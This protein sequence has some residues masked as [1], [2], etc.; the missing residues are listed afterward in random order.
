MLIN[1]NQS[2]LLF[3]LFP[4]IGYDLLDTLEIFVEDIVN[5]FII[6]EVELP[7]FPFLQTLAAVELG[8]GLKHGQF[9]FDGFQFVEE[10]MVIDIIFE[11]FQF[12]EDAVVGLWVEVLESNVDKVV[13]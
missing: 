10:G 7:F 5:N 13:H 1:I 3:S 6:V 11:G 8:F 4:I 2:F 12:V 9:E